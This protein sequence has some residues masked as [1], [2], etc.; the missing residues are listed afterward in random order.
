MTTEEIFNKFVI[1]TNELSKLSQ[2]EQMLQYPILLGKFFE[3]IQMDGYTK[4]FS[5]GVKQRE[6]DISKQN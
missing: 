3:E 1:L 2:W 6:I 4:G 5:D